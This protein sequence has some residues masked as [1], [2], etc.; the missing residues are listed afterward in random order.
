MQNSAEAQL[1][2]SDDSQNAEANGL[3]SFS[4][5]NI[6]FTVSDLDSSIKWYHDIFGFK[7]ISRST[8][9]LPTGNA[10]AAIIE[11]ADLRLELLHVHGGKRIE[12]LFA[13]VP[14]HLIPIGNK[15]IVF[16]VNNVA[17]ATKELEKKGVAF[18][19]R[20]QYLVGK[21]MLCTMVQDIDGNK[22]N[23]F[24]SNTII[25][26]ERWDEPFNAGEIIKEH[27]SIWSESNEINADNIKLIDP[28][29]TSTGIEKL[30]SFINELQKNHPGY[31]FSVAGKIIS[32]HNTVKFNWNYG[33]KS[34][35]KEITGTDLMILENGRIKSLY[36][37][38][39]DL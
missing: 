15:S 29:F 21:S 9:S 19:W 27:L 5:Y 28:F 1:A 26:N 14:K 36:V 37:F 2:Y 7:L 33:S 24:Q 32:H 11:G 18:V 38:I 34:N 6:A 16:Q 30:N 31:V 22:I 17:L 39:N 20:E 25:G 13:E 23:I 10:E 8:F 3:L 35:P 12:D 4:L